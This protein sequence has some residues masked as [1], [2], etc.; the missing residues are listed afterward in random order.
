M[1]GDLVI[2]QLIF[3]NVVR[4]QLSP[5]GESVTSVTTLQGGYNNPLDVTVG[6][7]GIIY[8]AEYGANQIAFLAPIAVGGATELPFV[9]GRAPGG[10]D[11]PLLA[12]LLLPV[13]GF[14]APLALRVRR[15]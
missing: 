6:P 1:Q 3:G 4:A 8:I 5:D 10:R 12:L 15:H 7:T 9:N 14:G 2:A 11:W 13:L